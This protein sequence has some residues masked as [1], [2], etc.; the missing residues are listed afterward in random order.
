MDKTLAASEA[1]KSILFLEAE[2]RSFIAAEDTVAAT[3]DSVEEARPRIALIMADIAERKL[4]FQLSS[5]QRSDF[6]CISYNVCVC[7]CTVLAEFV[8]NNHCCCFSW[9]GRRARGRL[10]SSFKF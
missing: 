3:I 2:A 7:T 8:N 1:L 10:I 4:Q 9:P 6:I 5:F